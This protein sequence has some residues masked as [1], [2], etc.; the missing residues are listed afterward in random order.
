MRVTTDGHA[1]TDVRIV[2][3]PQIL[4]QPAESNVRTWKFADHSP[5]TFTVT[6]VYA[7]EGYFKKDPVTN[8]D[9]K[10][11]FPAEV[12]VSTEI[13]FSPSDST[14]T[15]VSTQTLAAGAQSIEGTTYIN[16]TAHF[17]L[18]VPLGW[19]VTDQLI[20]TTADVV[21]TV[22]APRGGVAIMIQRFAYPISPDFA[23]R[24]VERGFSHNF[25]GYDKIRETP[26]KIGGEDAPSFTF[27]FEGP[28]KTQAKLPGEMFVVFVRNGGGVLEFM[29][30]APQPL[31]DQTE[32]TFEKIVDSYH[33]SASL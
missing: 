17:T 33:Y 9:A 5:T 14:Q 27:R 20:R 26:M 32:S 25:S 12:T 28:P 23:E 22:A 1:V 2:S 11:N 15:Q 13:P 16:H 29:C 31:F 21:G 3:G 30:Y 19:R 7:N 18:N 8:C 4:A 6:Y 10:T 24:I